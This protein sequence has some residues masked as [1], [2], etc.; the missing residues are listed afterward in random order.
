ME[1]A[2]KTINFSVVIPTLN[3]ER[4]LP[5]LLGDLSRQT[6]KPFEVII[7]D[8]KSSDKTVVKAKTFNSKIS[9]LHIVSSNKRNVAH[10]RNLGASKASGKWIIFMDADSRIPANFLEGVESNILETS[11]DFFT[12]W[13]RYD[14]NNVVDKVMQIMTNVGVEVLLSAGLPGSLGALTGIKRAHWTKMGGFDTKMAFAE[15]RDFV[16]KCYKGGLVI[17]VFRKPRF[18]YSLRRVRGSGRLAY[19]KKYLMLNVK[20]LTRAGVNREDY[21]MG[22]GVEYKRNGNK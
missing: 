7:V 19:Y 12:C 11:P 17:K 14:S 3:E 1:G 5:G 8:G 4:F 10:Q 9:E 21:P 18:T 15:D 2:V 6:R 16:R 13:T 20:K 22:G